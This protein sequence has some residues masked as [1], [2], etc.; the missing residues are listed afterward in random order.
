M[1]VAQEKQ[2]RLYF[3]ALDLD[4]AMSQ[5]T[6]AMDRLDRDADREQFRALAECV[7]QIECAKHE[8]AIEEV[9]DD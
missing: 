2:N 8:L 4:T 3:A 7:Q 9:C 6:D 1:M 5:V